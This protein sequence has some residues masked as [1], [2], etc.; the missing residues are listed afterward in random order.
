MILVIDIGNTFTKLAVFKQNE[1]QHIT[2]YQALSTGIIKELLADYQVNK[3]IISSVKKN[4]QQKWEAFLAAEIS[5]VYFNNSMTGKVLNH[6]LTPN[7]LGLDRL[8]AV[9]GAAYLYPGQN[10]LVIDGG[11]CITM[12]IGLMP[13]QIILA[14]V[15][16]RD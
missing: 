15:Y 13:V 1:L 7:T 16:H 14:A 9:I 11:T 3:A 6:Y 2:Q 4:E 10:S 5:L 12:M 8:A